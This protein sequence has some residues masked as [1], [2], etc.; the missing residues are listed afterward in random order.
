MP[1]HA[2]ASPR[3]WSASA[4]RVLDAG[5]AVDRA[6][7][8]CPRVRRPGAARRARAHH[9]PAHQRAA[10]RSASL[11]ALQSSDAAGRRRHP[12]AVRERPRGVIRRD[13]AGV[14]AAGDP[15][16]AHARARRPRRRST[17]SAAWPPSCPSTRSARGR[18]GSSTTA[19]RREA[20]AAQ[21]DAWWREVVAAAAKRRRSSRRG[22]ATGAAARRAR[23]P[24]GRR[25]AGCR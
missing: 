11:E 5:G 1:G 15:A 22:A 21:V 14:R 19:A 24:P 7:A 10:C 4:P 2:R 18:P 25:A 3:W 6:G 17:R 9:P 12:P 8:R 20:T 23:T 13:H 16:A